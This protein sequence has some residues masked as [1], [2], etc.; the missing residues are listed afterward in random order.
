MAQKN[1]SSPN[2][3]DIGPIDPN[4]DA[5]VEHRSRRSGKRGRDL[6][7]PERVARFCMVGL[8]FGGAFGS[9]GTWTGVNVK[10]LG[11]CV[12]C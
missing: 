3:A 9:V 1:P 2:A 12:V 7:N 8:G 4:P 6:E 11:V 10:V 5:V